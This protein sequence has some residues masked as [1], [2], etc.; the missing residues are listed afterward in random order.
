MTPGA[1]GIMP[2]TVRKTKE[3]TMATRKS[4]LFLRNITILLGFVA[5]TVGCGP[6]S[7]AYLLSP[8]VD[9][10]VQPKCPLAKP[11]KALTKAAE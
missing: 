2:R 3:G 1:L 8:F 6:S 4:D 11:D 9:D 5:M 10:R 7:L